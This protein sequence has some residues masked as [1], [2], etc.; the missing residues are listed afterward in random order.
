MTSSSNSCQDRGHFICFHG[1]VIRVGTPYV[2]DSTRSFE[3]NSIELK[4]ILDNV[5]CS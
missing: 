1:T 5:D 3:C 2:F 4:I